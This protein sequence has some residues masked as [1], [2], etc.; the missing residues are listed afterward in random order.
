MVG[1]PITVDACGQ[2]YLGVGVGF[3]RPAFGAAAGW[4]AQPD[5]GVLDRRPP[6]GAQ[7]KSLLAGVGGM[8]GAG[9]G[10]EYNAPGDPAQNLSALIVTNPSF[11]VSYSVPFGQIVPAWLQD[12]PATDG[13]GCS[14]SS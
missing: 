6:T 4:L 7:L 2:L 9:V 11:G 8:Y 1:V 3:G 10:I 13:N 5:R 12:D 14:C